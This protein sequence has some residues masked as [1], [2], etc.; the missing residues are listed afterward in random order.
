M[1]PKEV[2][3]VCTGKV[4]GEI[5]SCRKGIHIITMLDNLMKNVFAKAR[6]TANITKAKIEVQETKTSIK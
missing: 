5:N 2:D 3:G 4:M 1:L 6:A